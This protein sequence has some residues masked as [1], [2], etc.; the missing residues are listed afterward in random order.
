VAEPGLV[1]GGTKL[2]LLEVSFSATPPA[3]G[4][5]GFQARRRRCLAA[6]I[7]IARCPV[8]GFGATNQPFCAAFGRAQPQESLGTGALAL[9]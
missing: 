1:R 4:I 7:A 6:I 8:R 9:I 2:F 3:K 5:G